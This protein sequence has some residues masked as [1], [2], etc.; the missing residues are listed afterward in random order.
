MVESSQ[1][2]LDNEMAGRRMLKI[3]K[4]LYPYNRS[5]AGPDIRF[6]MNYF[7]NLNKEFKPLKFKSGDKVQSIFFGY[8][9]YYSNCFLTVVFHV[10]LIVI[11]LLTPLMGGHCRLC[12][13]SL[14][15]INDSE[16]SVSV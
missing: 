8:P 13:H 1:S 10:Y 16:A 15:H 6:S 12:N 4:D 5:I 11:I 9:R 3:A 14:V 2:S 7:I